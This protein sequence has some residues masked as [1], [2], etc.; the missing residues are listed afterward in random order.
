MDPFSIIAAV[1]SFMVSERL[2]PPKSLLNAGMSLLFVYDMIIYQHDYAS[3]RVYRGPGLLAFTLC[4]IAYSLRT[5]RRNGIACDELLFLPGT[6][7]AE[8]FQDNYNDNAD[9]NANTALENFRKGIPKNTSKTNIAETSEEIIME[10]DDTIEMVPIINDSSSNDNIIE[11]EQKNDNEGYGYTYSPSAPSVFGASL[12]LAFPVLFNFHLFTEAKRSIKEIKDDETLTNEYIIANILPLIFLTVLYFR[13]I[14]PPW[15]RKRF[16][17]VLCHIISSPYYKIIFRDDVIGNLI[18]SFVRSMQD[19]IFTFFYYYTVTRSV[20]YPSIYSLNRTSEYL[21]SN[22]LLHCIVSPMIA[23]APMWW[24]FL[25]SLRKY[26]DDT[27]LHN[28]KWVHLCHAFKYLTSSMIVFYSLTHPLQERR[29]WWFLG[30]GIVTMFQIYC[31]VFL[32]WEL[33]IFKPSNDNASYHNI[34]NTTFSSSPIN[35]CFMRFILQ[36]LYNMRYIAINLYHG[37]HLRP[38]KHVFK[39]DYWYYIIFFF[40]CIT[41]CCWMLNFLPTHYIDTT[42]DKIQI[43]RTFSKDFNAYLGMLVS[44]FEIMRRCLWCILVVELQSIKLVDGS[45]TRQN[46]TCNILSWLFG[47]MISNIYTKF[48]LV[49]S[50]YKYK[51]VMLDDDIESNDKSD[52]ENEDDLSHR[53]STKDISEEQLLSS[54][55]PMRKSVEDTNIHHTQITL[56]RRILLYLELLC[57]VCTYVYFGYLALS[58]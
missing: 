6:I 45:Y 43:V 23:I 54:P 1:G 49:F 24:K 41:R 50:S 8:Q 18:T 27:L 55:L 3:L 26:Y 35:Y 15:S 12:D 46:T 29:L 32:D 57:W 5:W 37:L 48:G 19:F 14:I 56:R 17:S 16:W 40:N 9:V 25:Q 39:D 4:C 31:D 10:E 22:W 44:V 34:S 53:S 7:Y 13:A 42:N 58:H 2:L 20:L 11:E 36:P 33:F 51:E 30:F 38:Q 21:E 28:N 52:I 47:P